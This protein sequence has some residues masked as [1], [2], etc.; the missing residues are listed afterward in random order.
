M[1]YFQM[2]WADSSLLTYRR[3]HSFRGTRG[4]ARHLQ[5]M[6]G[7]MQ[8]NINWHDLPSVLWATRQPM[9]SDFTERIWYVN[10]SKPCY[11][12]STNIMLLNEWTVINCQTMIENVAFIC[13]RKY[14][15]A[16]IDAILR[17]R[18]PITCPSGCILFK[19]Y[20]VKYTTRKNILREYGSY[21][22]TPQSLHS[23]Y[24]SA[25]TRQH[26]T[27]DKESHFYLQADLSQ[28]ASNCSCYA[29]KDLFF[30]VLKDWILLDC[31]C[32]KAHYGIIA[33]PP[34]PVSMRCGTGYLSCHDKSCYRKSSL[35][36]DIAD[37][38]DQS[39][40]VDCSHQCRDGF[41]L[42]DSCGRLNTRG[43]CSV[44]HYR[45][46]N[47]Q[48]LSLGKDYSISMQHPSSHT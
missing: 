23:G 44:I 20:C 35:C 43:L 19:D 28:V 41:D 4:I 33:V 30:Q 38:S 7:T 6:T 47:K 37:C 12:I 16:R 48:C 14:T 13:E 3:F 31:P 39:D 17:I 34:S 11:A 15:I 18:T 42:H 2:T 21:L 10:V 27:Q 32:D 24:L 45:C 8:R 5:T 46:L 26:H 29:T 1:Y 40:E 9:L 22:K 36:D 25:W